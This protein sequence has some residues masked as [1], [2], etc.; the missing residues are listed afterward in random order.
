[1]PKKASSAY[2][3]FMVEFTKESREKN[4]DIKASEHMSLAGK[5]WS[6][7]TDAE[8]KK[9]EELNIKDLARREK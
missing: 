7:L 6:T 5:K 4:P 9:Y 8:K 3:F 2:N 1:M